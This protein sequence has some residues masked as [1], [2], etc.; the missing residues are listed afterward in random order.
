MV[1]YLDFLNNPEN[2]AN[3]SM[4]GYDIDFSHMVELRVV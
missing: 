4:S 1:K 2:T 3:R